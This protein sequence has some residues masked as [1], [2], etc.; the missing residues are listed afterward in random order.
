MPTFQGGDLN[1][2]RNWVQEGL[3]YPQGALDAGIQ[4]RVVI[5]FVVGKEGSVT[6]VEILQSPD[7][8]LS[9]ARVPEMDARQGPG[10]ARTDQ[11]CDPDR[12]PPPLKAGTDG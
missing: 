4:G 3:R 5:T 1:T 6:D 7:T 8:R 12:L 10:E 2:F 11:V 9:A